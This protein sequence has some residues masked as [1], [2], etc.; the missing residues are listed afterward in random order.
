MIR[1]LRP[2]SIYDVLAALGFF[3]ALA[4]GG[5]YAANTVFSGDIVDGQV[6]TQDLENGAVAVTK[7]ANGG[8]TS[9]KVK[10]DALKGRDIE[11]QSLK[12]VD[13]DESTLS[14]IGGGG[15]AGGDLQGTYPNPTIAPSAVTGLEV[16]DS[17]L[18]GADVGFDSL[19]GS[20]IAES[21]LGRVPEAKQGGLGRYGFT[22][23]CDPESA[24]FVNCSNV[25]V[26][27]DTPAR[28][29]VIGSVQ[30]AD[31]QGTDVDDAVGSCRL[32]HDLRPD[33]R[34]RG[35]PV[36]PHAGSPRTRR[37][38][39]A[40]GG[41]GCA[42]GRGAL[43]RDRLQ[44]VRD[45]WCDRLRASPRRRQSRSR[46]ADAPPLLGTRIRAAPG[47][48]PSAIAAEAPL[49]KLVEPL[50]LGAADEQPVLPVSKDR[51]AAARTDPL[52][53]AEADGD[54]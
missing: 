51:A 14:N 8:I 32:R 9:D 29:L 24:T 11:D 39:D 42:S 1:R 28:L 13:I 18:G 10:D 30:W 27:L 52:R 46:A 53:L 45:C 16:A 48:R 44:S 17:A 37:R 7:I 33:R 35:R 5:A 22:G 49:S 15:P 31:E 40:R 23:S 50:R 4:T 25:A 12:G 2:R 41:D 38:C 20:D 6:K 43:G 19:D 26:S 34:V 3:I 54:G 21:T 36:G 47:G